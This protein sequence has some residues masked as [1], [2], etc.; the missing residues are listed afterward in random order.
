M[1]KSY[2]LLFSILLVCCSSQTYSFQNAGCATFDSQNNCLTCKD[3]YYMYSYLSLCLPVSPICHDYNPTTGACITCIDGF[4]MTQGVCQPTFNMIVVSKNQANCGSFNNVSQV[5]EKCIDAYT[6]IGGAC[7]PVILNC[8]TYSTDGKC[9]KCV[10][11]FSISGSACAKVVSVT[12]DANCK[13]NDGSKCTQCL[14]GFLLTSQYFCIK[15]SPLCSTYNLDGL[16][17]ACEPSFNLVSGKCISKDAVSTSW[18]IDPLCN[19]F[20]KG[21]CVKCS[22]GAYFNTNGVCKLG[23]PLCK[24]MDRNGACISCYSGFQVKDSTCVQ[25]TLDLDPNCNLFDGVKCVKCSQGAYFDT[26]GKCIVTDPNCKRWNNGLCDSCYPGFVM[27]D[28]GVCIIDADF[29]CADWSNGQCNRCSRGYY[30]D[31]GKCKLINTL[32][33]KFDYTL[34]KCTACY[35]GYAL[36]QG[37]CTDYSKLANLPG[38]NA[39]C[40]VYDDAGNCLECFE[41]FYLSGGKCQEVSPYCKTYNPI[42]GYCLSCYDG[43]HIDEFGQCVLNA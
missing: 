40:K 38:Y 27:N 32:C 7:Y 36:Y 42:K 13:I 1:N 3:R 39:N 21:T 28:K 34:K 33:S 11:G 19:R 25:V 41:R 24:E 35:S 43:Y 20:D 8:D 23:N 14:D 37:D 26:N 18:N 29:N 10:S 6:L 15:T 2:L 17:T 16:C 4:A 22:Y 5:C 9:T 31:G 12:I 30:L